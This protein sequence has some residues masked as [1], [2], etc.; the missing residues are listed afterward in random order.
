MA[1]VPPPFCPVGPRSEAPVRGA[2]VTNIQE[3]LVILPLLAGWAPA[4]PTRWSASTAIRTRR[5][6]RRAD[7]HP[8]VPLRH[9]TWMHSTEVTNAECSCAA[10][11]VHDITSH[12]I[13]RHFAPF[14]IMCAARHLTSG[15]SRTCG[16]RPALSAGRSPQHWSEPG[17]QAVWLHVI[18][19]DEFVPF[20]RL[21]GCPIDRLHHDR[22]L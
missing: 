22:P 17:D 2:A 4:N 6:A 12:P 15:T 9:L 18:D 21:A 3:W 11:V 1:A 19:I 20:V 13:E 14:S 8:L 16:R 5:A 7:R 10:E